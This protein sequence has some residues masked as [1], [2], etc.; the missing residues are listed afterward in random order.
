MAAGQQGRGQVAPGDHLQTGYQLWLP[1]HQIEKGRAPWRDRYSF[2]PLVERR[3]NFAGWPFGVAYWPLHRAFGAVQAWNAFVLLGFLG[4]GAFCALWLRELGI[5]RGA[6]LAGGLA[7]ALAPYVAGQMSAGHLLGWVSMLLPLS[8]FAWERGLRRSTWWLGL[9]AASLASIPLSGQ[10]HLALGAIPFFLLYALVRRRAV[11]VAVGAAL[12]GIGAG[13]LVYAVAIRGSVGSGSRSFAQVERYSAEPSDFLSRD[14]NWSEDFVFVGWLTPLLALTG[15]IVLLAARRYR[16][17][18]L[19]AAGVGVPVLLAL[20]ANLPGYETLWRDLPGLRD[21]RVPERLMPIACLALAA[22]AAHAVTRV[23]WPGTAAIVAAL[24]LVDLHVSVFEPTRADEN[25]DAY[26]ALRSAPPGRVLELPVRPPDRQE[27]SAYLY[28]AMQAQREHPSGYSTL[29]PR[30]ADRELRRLAIDP[31][32]EL[33]RLG[34][35]YLTLHAAA[36]ACGGRR[37]ARDGP[38]SLYALGR[39]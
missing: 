24:L 26:A 16:L 32:A 11:P 14:G 28:Y 23:R 2:Q 33:S 6:A 34:V 4:A 19:L 12:L 3:V 9:S 31:C 13:F 25:N 39:S 7:Y 8:L 15:L 36:P 18:A 22:L 30:E 17:G 35:R 10:V 29:A 37:L 5:R 20:G 38:I 1:G 27:A 21:T